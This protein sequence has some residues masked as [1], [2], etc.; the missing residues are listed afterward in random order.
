MGRRDRLA[1]GKEGWREV[2][3][4]EEERWERE[5]GEER[6]ERRGKGRKD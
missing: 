6:E 1:T 5:G 3:K 4:A 2:G